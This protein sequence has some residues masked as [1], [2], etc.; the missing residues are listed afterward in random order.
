MISF[1]NAFK[2]ALLF[3]ISSHLQAQTTSFQLI[4]KTLVGGKG[5]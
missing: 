1:K 2:M 4:K 3:L 5:G